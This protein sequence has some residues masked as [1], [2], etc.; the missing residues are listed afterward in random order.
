MENEQKRSKFIE[1]ANRRVGDILHKVNNLK[2][3][4]NTTSY[5]YTQ[6]DVDKI[7]GAIENAVA[8]VKESFKPKENKKEEVFDLLS[9]D[10][11]SES[12]D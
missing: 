8:N 6:K 1:I 2:P 12:E 3:L 9:D 4:A 10:E 7:F 5:S 11:E